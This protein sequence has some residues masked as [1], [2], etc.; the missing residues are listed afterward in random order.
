MSSSGSVYLRFRGVSKWFKAVVVTA[1]DA[2]DDSDGGCASDD[3]G[4]VAI[5][6]GGEDVVSVV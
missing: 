3:G 6:G 4:D 1:V 2:V 5:T